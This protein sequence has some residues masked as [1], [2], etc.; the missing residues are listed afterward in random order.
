MM[1]RKATAAKKLDENHHNDV[2]HVGEL[3]DL[4][5]YGR[6]QHILMFQCGMVWMA[7]AMEVN[8]CVC[9]DCVTSTRQKVMNQQSL[10]K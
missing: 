7:D 5:Q 2:Y 3:V 8:V 1:T 4:V 6:F 10:A 9:W